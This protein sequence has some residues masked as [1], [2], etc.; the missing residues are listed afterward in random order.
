MQSINQ[1]TLSN[2][3]EDPPHTRLAKEVLVRALMDSLG[4][5]SS[6]SGDTKS[7]LGILRSQANDFFSMN[8]PRFR[9]ICDI[10]MAEPSYIVKIHRSLIDH[11]KRGDLK[12][13]SLKVIVEKFIKYL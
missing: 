12:K 9:L 1:G 13:F 8:R 7:Q 11:K 10:A 4:S 2:K 6:T 3:R 5:L